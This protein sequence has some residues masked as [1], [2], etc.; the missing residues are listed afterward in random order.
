MNVWMF[1]VEMAADGVLSIFYS[2]LIH[3]LTSHFHHPLIAEFARVLCGETQGEICLLYGLLV[4]METSGIFLCT[5][6]REV[7]KWFWYAQN[8]NLLPEKV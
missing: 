8:I 7:S 6:S 5:D 2:H 4:L 3:I 1:L